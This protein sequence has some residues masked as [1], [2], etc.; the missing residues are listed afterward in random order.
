MVRV[1]VMVKVM[2]MVMVI[3]NAFPLPENI[4][5]LHCCYT[6]VQLLLPCR[7]IPV[8]LLSYYCTT[9]ILLFIIFFNKRMSLRSFVGAVRIQ[10]AVQPVCPQ[11]KIVPL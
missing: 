3:V 1:L 11:A 4:I 6:L 5:V 8:I 7:H 2:V 10:V 9:V